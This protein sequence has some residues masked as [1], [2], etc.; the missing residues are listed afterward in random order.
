MYLRC[1]SDLPA[2]FVLTVDKLYLIGHCGPHRGVQWRSARIQIHSTEVGD[3]NSF[4]EADGLQGDPS[5][6]SPAYG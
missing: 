3:C 1:N 4:R 5:P 2:N 6:R